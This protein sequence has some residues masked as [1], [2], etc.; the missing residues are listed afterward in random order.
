MQ[1]NSVNIKKNHYTGESRGF[2]FV[3]FANIEGSLRSQDARKAK[4]A[5]NHAVI[6][7]REVRIC[8]KRDFKNLDPDANVYVKNISSQVRGKQMEDEFTAFG[9]IFSCTVKYD[10]NGRHLG[11]GYV[12]FKEKESADKAI[13]ALNGAMIADSTIQVEKFKPRGKR[14]IVSWK[15]NLYV[16]GF[17]QSWSKKQVEEYIQQKFS[18]FADYGGITSTCVRENEKLGRCFA[19]IAYKSEDDAT[20]AMKAMN[21]AQVDQ[22]TL[23]VGYAQKKG[24]RRKQLAESFA[25]QANETNLF[26]KSLRE[27][28]TEAQLKQV[29]SKFGEVTSVAVQQST[30][31]PKSIESHGVKLNFGFV[32]FKDENCAKQAFLEAKKN[33]DIKALISEFHDDK[34]DFIYFAQPKNVRE[35]YLKM[36]RKNLQTTTLLQSQMNMFKMMMQMNNKRGGMTQLNKKGAKPT[37]ASQQMQSM[38]HPMMM[39]MFNPE[40]GAAMNPM[41]GAMQQPMMMMMPQFGMPA[42]HAAPGYQMPQAAPTAASQTTMVPQKVTSAYL[43]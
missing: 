38:M 17:P 12:Q 28:V 10:E 7:D 37:N 30:K 39:S 43:G 32:N 6:M 21:E 3:N 1:I 13:E 35:Q 2:A 22:D 25:K 16:K 18:I 19:F 9:P 15:T 40:G 5:L 26:I 8:F 29:F 41:M 24:L 23:Y 42:I 34:R 36:L 33:A 20:K 4:E 11:Y 27:D 31:V 14:N